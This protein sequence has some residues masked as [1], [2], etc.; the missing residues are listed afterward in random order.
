MHKRP[1]PAS[2]PSGIFDPAGE[3]QSAPTW[4]PSAEGEA[5]RGALLESPLFLPP[6]GGD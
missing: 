1:H 6:A 4:A 5:E 2:H 3:E